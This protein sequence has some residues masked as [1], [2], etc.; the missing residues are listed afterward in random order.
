MIIILRTIKYGS[1]HCNTFTMGVCSN[2][3]G[4]FFSLICE[5]REDS[6]TMEK[7]SFR[8]IFQTNN[9]LIDV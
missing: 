5:Y 6:H 2:Y 3:H 1:T 4:F 9:R 8:L 7:K